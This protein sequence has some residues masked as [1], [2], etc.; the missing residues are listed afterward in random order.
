MGRTRDT[1]KIF[2][3][4]QTID[5]SSSLDSRIFISSASPTSGNTNGRIWIDTSTASVPTISVFGNSSYRTPRF[6]RLGIGGDYFAEISGFRYHVFTSTGI[7]TPNGLSSINTLI[8]GGGGGGGNGGGGGGGAGG[9]FNY[10]SVDVSGLSSVAV[11][12]GAKGLGSTNTANRGGSGSPSTIIA[13]T[14]IT[15]D[16]G[17]GGGCG[18]E[19]D[20]EGGGSNAIV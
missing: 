18:E 6:G 11:T 15:A 14:T 2:T 10:T 3:S 12:V 17:G 19:K 7:F 9:L 8:I 4:L 16:G 1:S 20:S 13:K 5:V